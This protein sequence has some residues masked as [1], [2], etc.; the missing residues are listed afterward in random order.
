MRRRKTE[1]LQQPRAVAPPTEPDAVAARVAGH[2]Q[3]TARLG[4][5]RVERRIHVD[6][7][8]RPAGSLGRTDALSAATIRS[9]FSATG[10]RR[11]AMHRT[12]GP[13]R[14]HRLTDRNR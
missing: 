9:S 10:R 8:E 6:Q 7:I 3:R 11:L 4:A 2:R 13:Y 14:G 5:A 1:R 12:R